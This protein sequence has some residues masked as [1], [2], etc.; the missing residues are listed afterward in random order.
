MAR[1]SKS[2]LV[3]AIAVFCAL[4]LGV[5]IIGSIVE[6]QPRQSR[7]IEDPQQ[8]T[9][10]LVE[11]F[12]VEVKLSALYDLGV[13]PIGKKPNSVSVGNILEC[14]GGKD[15]GQVSTGAKLALHPNSSGTAKIT[16]TVYVERQ[17][18][19]AGGGNARRPVSAKSYVGCNAGWSFT[20]SASVRPSGRV[21]VQFDFSQTTYED[22][23][24]GRQMPPGTAQR[25][26]SGAAY[27]L[28]GEPA[29]VGAA[30][31][32]ETAVFLILCVRTTDA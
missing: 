8:E 28:T 16:E 26:F 30:Q 2:I 22:M 17:S 24:S 19:P 20:G 29:I 1:I 7:Q 14:L 27:L 3:L 10:V 4:L 23:D 12:V 13:S 18:S 32:E 31:D 5:H 11:A 21:L 15:L 25:D 6:A 9:G